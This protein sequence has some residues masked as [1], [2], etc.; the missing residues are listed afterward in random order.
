[1]IDLQQ[2]TPEWL[3]FRRR[4]IGA[5]DSPIIIGVSPW[6][7]PLQLWEEKLGLRQGVETIAMRRGSDLEHTA[8]CFYQDLMGYEIKPKVMIHPDF[9]WMMA[10]LDG[11]SV[12]G[13]NVVEIKCPGKKTHEMAECGIVPDHYMPQLQHQMSVA[14]VDKMEYVSFFEGDLRIIP[15]NRNDAMIKEIIQKDHRFWECLNSFSMPEETNRDFTV[16][17][18]EQFDTLAEELKQ[19]IISRKNLEDR[20]EYLKKCLIDVS[21]GKSC[22]NNILRLR[23]VYKKGIIDYKSIPDL[24]SVDLETYRKPSTEYFKFDML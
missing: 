23:K 9:D 20:E 14:G 3:E 16:I 1:M 7:T 17:T 10:S 5:S 18:D 21:G 12:D 19:I 24:K 13:K 8:R 6:K 4:K 2:N 11:M 15:V 22:K